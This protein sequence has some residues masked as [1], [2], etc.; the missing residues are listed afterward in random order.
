MQLWIECLGGLTLLREGAP[1]PLRAR[2]ARILLG[3]LAAARRRSMPRGRLAALLWEESDAEQARVSLRQAV[4]QIRRAGGEG[5]IEAEGDE[6]RLGPEVATDLD[7][8]Q[9][10]LSRGDAAEAARLYRGPFLDGQGSLSSD[11][12]QAIDADRA[13][14]AGLASTALAGELDRV[15]DGPDASALA[16][17]LLGLDPLNETAHRRLMQIEA[18]SGMRRA[19]RARYE[20]LEA[21][22]QRD[23]GVRP[24]D[25]TRSLYDRIR[26][27]L[28]ERA[29]TSE[30]EAAE[31]A[32]GPAYLLLGFETDGPRDWSALQAAALAAG[33]EA[34]DAGPAELAFLF[35]GEELRAVAVA[36]QE[37]AA[38][39]DCGLGFGLVGAA[40]VPPEGRTLV[41][42]RRIAALAGPGDVLLKRDL[43][44][45]L[46]LAAAPDQRAVALRP[47]AAPARPDL[48]LI[49]RE[50]ELAQ[51]EAAIAAARQSGRGLAIHVS[52]EAGIG[53]S[54]LAAELLRRADQ[55]GI[56]VAAIGFDAFSPGARHPAQRLVAALPAPP[57]P[58][59]DATATERAMLAWLS[60]PEIGP[61]DALRLSALDPDIQ[62]RLMVEGLA[63]ALKQAAA[64]T[65]LLVLIE[66]CHWSPLG[67]GDFLLGLLGHL[68]D[69]PVIL[70]LTERPRDGSLDLRLAA[71]AQAGVVRIA[72]SPLPVAA[73]EALVR[74]VAPGIDAA[75]AAIERAGGHPLFL[76]RLLEAGWTEGALPASVTELVQEQI[77]RLPEAD[78]A[79]IRRAAIL[80]AAFDP[81]DFAAIFPASPRP[82][83][84]GDL[85][86]A[87]GAGLAF[88]HDLVH[89]A[90][91]ESIPPEIR[92][93]DHARAAAHFRAR[94]AILWAD[95]ARQA[96]DDAEASRAAA[97]AANTMIAARRF[98][99]AYPYI[100]AG[101]ASDGDPEAVAE[102]HSCRAGL[103]RIR[104]EMAGALDDYRAAHAR[105]TRPETRAAML[106][107]QGLVLHR[108]GRGDEADRALDA[109][110][111]IADDIGLTGLGRAEIHEQR[112]NRAFVLGA[113][114]ACLAHHR[115]ALAA[116]EVT[117]DPRGIARGHGGIGDAFYA[118]GR[119]ASAHRHFSLAI[120]T[121]E[122]AGLGLVR[123]EYLFMRAFS[124][125]FADPG[126]QAHLLI[127]IAVDSARQCGATRAEMIARECRAEMRLMN[128]DEAGLETDIAAIEALALLRGETR[129]SKD[130]ETLHAFLALRRGDVASARARLEA[131]LPGAETDAYVGGT[132]FGLATLAAADREG[133]DAAIAA[134]LSC[135]SRRSLAHAVVW[136]HA[137]VLERAIA[138][139]DHPLARRHA[140]ALAAFCDPEPVGLVTLYLRAIELVLQPA[141]PE[142]L[143][144]HVQRL[145]AAKLGDVASM[146]QRQAGSGR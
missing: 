81:E 43:A 55:A 146:L 69:S 139:N 118:A 34:L 115:A 127:D 113:N 97:A 100:E 18:S 142:E 121:A 65:G 71:R 111:E 44:A 66:D 89:R 70:L 61:E 52:G 13:R 51:A 110:E 28:G 57:K 98:S 145:R 133:R 107:R 56:G 4:A 103:R 33:G 120:E 62:Q 92:R 122:R 23:L 128:G 41:E 116:A 40:D 135:T 7:A 17:R 25:E 63:R 30:P 84:S 8:F 3:L 1:V 31:D 93:A 48:P 82:R 129:F 87:T 47:G 29:A 96:G 78:R 53:K 94:D 58:A 105:A 26:R 39:A 6:L 73:S 124:L 137:C 125:F 22:L 117:G 143:L 2:K 106:C 64:T 109:A 79:A 5:W 27:G 19:A 42:A 15:G 74:A 123:E 21:A 10:A 45:R 99:A 140:E 138:D 85:L 11:L 95:H 49:G 119:F 86:H 132:I 68:Q 36:A 88:G 144:A 24:E 131:L 104:G 60:S 14:L 134:G 130:V 114:D 38:A 141:P 32:S 90:I 83:Q 67:A 102:L 35:V 112:G 54:R 50:L 20:A 136:F 16:H 108:M 12:G 77:E 126:P 101:L 80:G 9:A 46:G 76:I 37:I 91:Y 75:G 59:P 72:L